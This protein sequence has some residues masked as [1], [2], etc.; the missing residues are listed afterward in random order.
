MSLDIQETK[1]DKLILLPE[2]DSNNPNN[3]DKI[4]CDFILKETLGKGTFGVVK[5]AVNSQT[6]EKAAIKIINESKLPKEEKLNFLREIEILRNLKHPNIIRL[7]SHINKEKQLYLITEYI[8]GIEL[9]QYISLKKKIPESEACI[10]FQQIISGLEYLHKM[11]IVHRD[12]KPENILVDHHLKEIKIIDFGLSNKYTKNSNLLST[13]CGSPLY[14]APE[15]LQGRG[16][17]PR[18]VD[19]WSCGVV[20]YFMLCGKLPFQGDSDEDLYK[21][22]IDAKIK[23]IEGVSKEVNDL[24]RNILNPNPRKRIT[25]SKI[26]IHP[27]FNL[28]N[29]NFI[30]YNY[31]G[32]LTNKYVIPID[33]EI[34][35]EIKNRFNISEEEIR[36]SILGNKLNDIS[37]IYYLIVIQKSKENK[38]SISDFKSDIFIN[39]IKDKNNLLK[40]YSNDINK[41]I[42]LRKK[43]IEFESQ[44]IFE[45]SNSKS[46][47]GICLEKIM[48]NEKKDLYRS[49]SPTTKSSKYELLNSNC[50]SNNTRLKSPVS[51]KSIE[52]SDILNTNSNLK[53]KGIDTEVDSIKNKGLGKYKKL[54]VKSNTNANQL[55]LNKNVMKNIPKKRKIGKYASNNNYNFNNKCLSD[56]NKTKS[57]NRCIT[58]LTYNNLSSEKKTLEEEKYKKTEKKSENRSKNKQFSFNECKSKNISQKNT[59]KTERKKILALN[60]NMKISNNVKES[61]A[62]SLTTENKT[63]PLHSIKEFSHKLK[64]EKEEKKIS[65]FKISISNSKSKSNINKEQELFSSVK[66]HSERNERKKNQAKKQNT[67]LLYKKKKMVKNNENI[68]S[69]TYSSNNNNKKEMN[70]YFS[71]DFIDIKNSNKYKLNYDTKITKSNLLKVKN[72][73]IN[74]EN[75]KLNEKYREILSNP[76]KYLYTMKN[77]DKHDDDMNSNNNGNG[78][79]PFDLNGIYLKKKGQIKKEFIEKLEK[80]KIKYKKISNYSFFIEMKNDISFESEI[81]MN[82]NQGNNFCVLKI[83]KIKGNNNTI[84]N[85]LKKIVF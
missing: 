35:L 9:F 46:I 78:F 42:R 74:T 36:V 15:V 54:F 63:F 34:V 43:G 38:Q 72:L 71:E 52:S 41:V 53:Y 64:K 75:D 70:R 66:K 85:C 8:K 33:E 83:K 45:R 24:L 81:K 14:A 56:F 37:T 60:D 58:N 51:L 73:K 31:Y 7:Y 49:L 11:G 32:L 4:I 77:I 18:P 80:K 19:I 61:N 76:N 40:K 3:H 16:Y 50:N 57:N 59:N 82:K 1:Q 30:H 13:L 27:W 6:G 10:Y 29:N 22:I 39:Y 2:Y 21:K 44:I 5:L 55:N 68:I 23:N 62:I 28:F 47:K 17:K 26:K 12:I 79:E 65:E 67:G 25:I 20:L 48:T 84:F 69:E